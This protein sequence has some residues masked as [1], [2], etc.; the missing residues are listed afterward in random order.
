M[1]RLGVRLPEDVIYRLK[2]FAARRGKKIQEAVSE[3]LNKALKG[4]K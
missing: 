1:K 2:I 4:V 3:I